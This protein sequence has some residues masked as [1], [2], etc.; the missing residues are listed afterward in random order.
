MRR[1]RSSGLA[2]T[3]HV[4]PRRVA[5]SRAREEISPAQRAADSGQALPK[6]VQQGLWTCACDAEWCQSEGKFRAIHGFNVPTNGT[7]AQEFFDIL[8]PDDS[9]TDKVTLV[10]QVSQKPYKVCKVRQTHFLPTDITINPQRNSLKRT[11]V[12]RLAKQDQ[13]QPAAVLPPPLAPPP[14]TPPPVPP[15]PPS[16]PAARHMEGVPAHLLED[17]FVEKLAREN[18]DLVR[19]IQEHRQTSLEVR[20][21]RKENG[22]LGQK[23]KALVKTSCLS[24]AKMVA[25]KTL[26]KSCGELTPFNT[27]A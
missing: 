7:R 6:R 25:D 1:G 18:C 20:D 5:V 16:P 23:L 13:E 22:E 11:A 3:P 24:W 10:A 19:E 15:P 2:E 12:P 8:R 14:P 17:E 9:T 4:S 21:L 27:G 26:Q